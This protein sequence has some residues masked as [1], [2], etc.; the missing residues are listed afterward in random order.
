MDYPPPSFGEAVTLDLNPPPIRIP[1]PLPP[2]PP[3]VTAPNTIIQAVPTNAI[4][5]VPEPANAIEAMPDSESLVQSK[6]CNEAPWPTVI[7]ALVGV[8]LVI[9]T[10]VAPDIDS[11]VR[12]FGLVLLLLWTILWGILLWVLWHE[13]HQTVAWWLLILPIAVM[14]IFFVLIIILKLGISP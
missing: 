1:P 9:Y 6:K 3:L 5:A 7:V 2:R 11:N 13:C 14:L 10:G 8:G 12:I 4:A